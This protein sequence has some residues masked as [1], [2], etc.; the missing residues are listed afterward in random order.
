MLNVKKYIGLV[1][2]QDFDF[3][4]YFNDIFYSNVDIIRLCTGAET[5][6]TFLA[7]VCYF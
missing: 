1:A 4:W 7:E 3:S 5:H 2:K 6:Y